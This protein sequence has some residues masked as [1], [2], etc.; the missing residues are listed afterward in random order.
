MAPPLTKFNFK[1]SY[2]Y[3]ALAILAVAVGAYVVVNHQPYTYKET[4]VPAQ[5]ELSPRLQ[6]LFAKTKTV[7]FGRY[8]LDVPEEAQLVFGYQEFPAKITTHKDAVGRE[9]DLAEAFRTKFQGEHPKAEFTYADVGPVPNSWQLHFF[10]SP[11]LKKVGA[12]GIRNFVT[13]GK[14]VFEFGWGSGDEETLDQV[15]KGTTYIAHNLRARDNAEIPQEPGVCIDEG[16]IADNSG[17]FQEIFGAGIHIPSIPDVSFSI[18]SNKDA[19]TEGPNG[20]GL[21]AR[22]EEAM[23]EQGIVFPAVS[24]MARLRIGKRI[25]NGWN[26]EEV[27]LRHNGK[28]GAFAH[29]FMWAFVGTT[30]EL[31]KPASVDIQL[32]TGVGANTKLA[33]KSSL[34]D[35]EAVALWDKLLSGLR[36]R[37]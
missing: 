24:D 7:C 12:E 18:M 29:E 11:Y 28:D 27:L 36:F 30:G 2:I 6:K 22:H 37:L 4:G 15:M 21:A 17:K 14:D 5:V 20:V 35:D 16:F 34:T 31:T 9:K 10:G 23:K 13:A 19:S 26:G 3:A 1:K 8:V 25:A 32:D 33:T